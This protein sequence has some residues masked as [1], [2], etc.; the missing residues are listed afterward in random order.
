M[1]ST[2]LLDLQVIS[3][4]KG[5]KEMQNV[6]LPKYLDSWI[7]LKCAFFHGLI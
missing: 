3:K 5:G 1:K 2:M 4:N 7:N 6:S